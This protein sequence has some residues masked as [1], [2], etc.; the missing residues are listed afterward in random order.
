MKRFFDIAMSV[1]AL[2]LLSPLLALISLAIFLDDGA[3]VIF[4]QK[5]VGKNNALFEI[6]KFRTMRRDTPSAASRDM[7]RED[8]FTRSGRLLRAA[9]LDELPQ[10]WNIFTGT[11]SFVGPR[12]LIPEES[13]IRELRARAG[14]YKALPGLTGW[15]QV[16]GRDTL[17]DEEKVRLDAEYLER[18]GFWLDLRILIKTA[19]QVIVGKDVE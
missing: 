10:L 16:N 9:S 17:G 1:T 2:I 14:I 19:L 15:A 18:Q 7:K 3:P 13:K 11:M 5:R 12:P 8:L 6:L 4:R